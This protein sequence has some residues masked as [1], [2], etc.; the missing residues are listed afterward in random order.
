M[1]PATPD[2]AVAHFR[3]LRDAAIQ[4]FIV[5]TLDAADQDTIRLL[6][7]GLAANG[8]HLQFQKRQH[9]RNSD[10]CAKSAKMCAGC[11]RARTVNVTD[12]HAAPLAID[13]AKRAVPQR[14]GKCM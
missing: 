14:L 5:E 9:A 3:A 4:Y 8:F 13:D 12:L 10:A 2:R 6:A 11:A 1:F 7:A